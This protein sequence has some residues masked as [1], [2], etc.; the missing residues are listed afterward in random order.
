MSKRLNFNLSILALAVVFALTPFSVHAQEAVSF[1]VSPSIF[2]MTANPSQT[3][4]STLRVI[5]VN[6]FELIVYIDIANFIPKDEGGV[7]KFIPIDK[8]V[9]EQATF[10]EWISTVKEITIPPEQTVEIPLKIQVPSDASPGGHYAAVMVST[11]PTSAQDNTNNVQ[12]AQ[13]ISSLIFLRVTGDIT[14]NSTIRSFRTADYFI[15][16][17]ETNFEIRIENK[18]NVHVQPQG[19]IKIFNMWGQERGIVPINQQTLFGNVLPNS[20]RKFSFSWKSEWSITDIGRYRAVATMAYGVDTRQF[21]TADTAFWVIPWKI[22]LV[23]FSVV[24]GFIALISWAIKLYVRR[25]LSLAG[26]TPPT[27][28]VATPVTPGN[29][30]LSKARLAAPLEAGILDLRTR[31]KDSSSAV[32]ILKTISIFV[33]A[34]WKF[35]AVALAVIIFAALVVWFFK[36]AFTPLRDYEVLVE[37]EGAQVKVNSQTISTQTPTPPVALGKGE[38]VSLVNR[39]G[40]DEAMVLVSKE[41]T[42]AGFVVATSTSEAGS[43]EEKTVV[44]YSPDVA[45]TAIAVSKVLDGALLSAF[46]NNASS[47]ASI[48]VYIGTEVLTSD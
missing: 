16:R 31:L 30:K 8:S 17:P 12:T 1:S 42:A 4:Q 47:S 45:D 15:S 3:W 19:E 9:S 14:E 18:G 13:I 34:Y 2:D 35:F 28:A 21:M 39:S 26:I 5:N 33:R 48:V 37:G 27:T 46:V 24:G 36:G 41:L 22:L 23:I 44:V 6:S 43:I 25:M 29:K 20:V 40:A 10:A 11:R 32:A 38:L 7:P